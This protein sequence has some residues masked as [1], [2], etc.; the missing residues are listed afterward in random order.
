MAEFHARQGFTARGPFGFGTEQ[1]RR[2]GTFERASLHACG[3]QILEHRPEFAHLTEH[4]GVF[5]GVWQ[6]GGVEG[7]RS[8][9]G[10]PPLEKVDGVG[11]HGHVRKGVAHDFT[12]TFAD[13]ERLPLYR[14]SGVLHHI[15]RLA[16][17][18]R[19]HE[20]V[21]TGE[22]VEMR[23]AF[24][25]VMI[26]GDE[27]HFFGP[28]G[29][30]HAALV[31]G[32]HEVRGEWLVGADFGDGVTLGLVEVEQ[33]IVAE[34]LEIQFLSG[35]DHAVGAHE[36][37]DEHFV[38]AVH[39]LPPEG[40][41]PSRVERVDGAVFALTPLAEG[42]Q[43]VVGVVF[44]VV[45]AIFVAHVPS[46]HIWIVAI[47]FGEFTTHGKRICFEYRAGRAPRLTRAGVDLMTVFV[48]RKNLRMA[49]VQPKRSGGGGGS[50]IDRDARF[51][52]LVDDAVEPAE[53][54]AVLGGLDAIP[55]KNR[56]GHGVDTGL[57]H[58][59]DVVVPDFLR[60]LVGIVV[61]TERYATSIAS[62]QSRPRKGSSCR[63]LSLLKDA[64]AASDSLIS[65]MI[66]RCS[67]AF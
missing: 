16:E 45:P 7:L 37:R 11:A 30:V 59:A 56:Q 47:A 43:G 32:D 31:G 63:H 46:R 40:G 27:I 58:Q 28:I 33:H 25:E 9:C 18:Q 65:H 36:A 67:N 34:S 21:G 54:P 38:E 35:I 66:Q 48:S 53:V 44:A 15:P 39:L 64:F 17:R 61:A 24:M 12:L 62:Q 13:I 29:I 6:H 20:R 49:F 3:A 10:S 14:R 5:T 23:F 8:E 22:F 19:I 41:A 52:E 2:I 57:L 50:K 26:V 51:A 1:N 60:P 42:G 55:A 4:P